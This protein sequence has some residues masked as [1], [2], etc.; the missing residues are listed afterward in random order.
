M[1]C[2]RRQTGETM[3]PWCSKP[4]VKHGAGRFKF[5]VLGCFQTPAQKWL[6]PARGG[7]PLH[8]S[9]TRSTLWF[10]LPSSYCSR[11][12][13]PNTSKLWHNDLKTSTIIQQSLGHLKTEKVKSP[14]WHHKKLCGTL[15]DQAA[16][17]QVSRCYSNVESMQLVCMQSLTQKGDKPNTKI[18]W[19]DSTPYSNR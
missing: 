1:V 7:A 19:K 4:T 5:Q 15:S 12:M 10:D 17:T 2:V 11:I 8:S 14:L 13:S 16:I 18:F 3:T 9:E 6:H